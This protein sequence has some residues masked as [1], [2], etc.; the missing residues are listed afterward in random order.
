MPL[1]VINRFA[2]LQKQFPLCRI[3]EVDEGKVYELYD[4]V[5]IAQPRD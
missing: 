5:S 4:S 2:E 3:G 1:K